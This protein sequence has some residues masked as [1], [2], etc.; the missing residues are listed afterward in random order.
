MNPPVHLFNFDAM[1]F[2]GSTLLLML[3]F[4]AIYMY[5]VSSQYQK[6]SKGLIAKK[7]YRTVLFTFYGMSF[8]SVGSHLAEIYMWGLALHYFGLVPNLDQ[9]ILFAGSAYTTVG[10]GGIPL[11]PGWDLLMIIIALDGM[12][13]FGWTIANLA[14]MIQTITALR[15]LTKSTGYFM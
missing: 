7:H 11:P 2:G 3:I 6:I 8:V 5:F 1:F 15:R 10:F 9:A 14:S 4:H 12:V 13:A